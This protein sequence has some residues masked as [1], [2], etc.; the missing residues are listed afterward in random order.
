MTRWWRALVVYPCLSAKADHQCR[1]GEYAPTAAIRVRQ[2]TRNNPIMPVE[3]VQMTLPGGQVVTIET[4]KYAKQAG[5]AVTVRAGD[6][7]VLATATMASEPRAGLDFFPLTCDYEERK[8]AVGKIPGGFVKRGGRPGEKAILTSRLID[9]PLRP[10]FPKGM[11]HE[12]Q[13]I[14][15]PLSAD[16]DHLPDVYA[17]LGASAALTISDIPFAGPI[18]AVRVGLI[19]GEFVIN[20]TQSQVAESTLDLVVAGTEKA[21]LMVEAGAS[22]VSEAQM[23]D[24]FDRAHEVI[25][26]QCQVLN[27]LRTRVG[28]EKRQV[29]LHET[30]QEILDKVRA[31]FG[32]TLRQGLQDPDKAAREAGLTLLIN[33][34]VEKMT[35]E[36]PDNTA[37]LREVGDKVVK[38]QLRDLILSENKRPDGRGPRDIRQITCEVGLLP[39]VHGSGLFTRGQTQVLTSVT[40]GSG[41]DAQ[42]VD[43]LEEDSE[44]R[45]MHFYNFPPYSVGEARP[46][47][48]PGR[49]EIGHGALA[50]RALVPVVPFDTFP[51]TMLLQSEV[52]ESNGSTSMASTCGSTLALMDAGV[53]IKSPVAGIAMGLITE[54]D[55]FAVLTDIQGMEDFSGDM[56]FKVAGTREGI[57]ALQL[58]TKIQGIPRPVF[59]DA[60]E[61]AREARLHIL[62]KIVEAISAPRQELS[63]YAPRIITIKIDP[64]QIGSVIGPG[65]KMIKKITADTGAKID[66]EQDGTVN[67]ASTDEGGEEA[68]RIIESMT[69]S[70]QPGEVYEGRIV[71]FLQFG[72]FVELIPGKDALGHVSQI[73][74]PPPARPD[75]T[76]KLG[77]TLRV[78]VTEIDGQGRVNAT[79]RGLDEPFDPANPEPGRPP[80][81]SAPAAPAPAAIV[82]VAATVAVIAAASVVDATAAG[83]TVGVSAP[84]VRARA[85]AT[86]LA[87]RRPRRLPRLP[88]PRALNRPRTTATTCP[89]PGS[90]PAAEPE[91][92]NHQ[93]RKADRRFACRPFAWPKTNGS[94]AE[95][96][97]GCRWYPPRQPAATWLH[98]RQRL[99]DQ[100]GNVG[101]RIGDGYAGRL[102]RLD[103]ALG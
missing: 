88:R 64:E 62:D 61:Q 32:A 38:E 96:S 45:Y 20:P 6:T 78:R 30:N 7:I 73:S 48:G 52:L 81:A 12:V 99:L 21:I 18:G 57:T 28:K 65:G 35:P 5:G 70:V 82:T 74:D 55:K 33:D 54:G 47:R 31:Q 75:E 76:L 85:S 71:R 77:D 46:M 97:Q 95:H 23:L 91:P 34:V 69:K 89:A 25:R 60:F 37:D 4:G 53:P 87:A 17:M 42:T 98:S 66:I 92:V 40:L 19:D 8:Y 1:P 83:A 79:A 29:P 14:A 11:R 103:L 3:S 27:E 101:G 86:A 41:G 100:V 102:Q 90:A 10:L 36:Y 49:R 15:M 67:I 72:A 84:A 56:D 44:K 13:V 39:R 68:R 63:Q 94:L 93:I 2:E 9:R 58:D 26:Q 51:Y 59:V 24:A 80:A 16:M 22:E 43:T 50:E